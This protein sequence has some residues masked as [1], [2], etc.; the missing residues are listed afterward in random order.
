MSYWLHE[1]LPY[2]TFSWLLELW[3]TFFTHIPFTIFFSF[4]LLVTY[5]HFLN[6]IQCLS[7]LLIHLPKKPHLHL[8]NWFPCCFLNF[9]ELDLYVLNTGTFVSALSSE[10]PHWLQLISSFK[11]NPLTFT[12]SQYELLT[13]YTFSA[14]T[15]AFNQTNLSPY[16][17]WWTTFII[18]FISLKAPDM[19]DSFNP[20]L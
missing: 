15:L 18:F 17:F 6:V 16:S 8:N 12:C 9:L 11:W 10:S 14:S 7:M 19:T 1:S 2:T 3:S 13:L 4:F 20:I 5:P